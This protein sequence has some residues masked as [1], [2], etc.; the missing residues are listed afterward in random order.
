MHR[1]EA[2]FTMARSRSGSSRTARDALQP[3]WRWR[4]LAYLV[5]GSVFGV[6]F[7]LLWVQSIGGIGLDKAVAGSLLVAWYLASGQFLY[8]LIWWR[9][10]RWRL[11]VPTNVVAYSVFVGVTGLLTGWYTGTTLGQ[12][13]G[14]VIPLG[15]AIGTLF[16]LTWW[17]RKD[18]LRAKGWRW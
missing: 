8:D 10:H 2:A 13:I 9:W 5:V 14:L 12:W 6:L 15:L 7:A 3:H 18:R 17:L 4:S 1:Q 16:T 11:L